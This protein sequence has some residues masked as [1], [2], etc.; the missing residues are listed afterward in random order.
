MSRCGKTMCCNFDC[1]DCYPKTQCEHGV[2]IECPDCNSKTYTDTPTEESVASMLQNVMQKI[3]THMKAEFPDMTEEQIDLM[4]I[5]LITTDELLHK[6]M[7]K[8]TNL[9]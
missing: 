2:G 5:H 8:E 3:H 4:V 6:R 1:E 7:L 9:S